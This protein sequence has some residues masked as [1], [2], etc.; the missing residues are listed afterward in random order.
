MFLQY[1]AKMNIYDISKENIAIVVNTL[2]DGSI[3]NHC[4]NNWDVKRYRVDNVFQNFILHF[5]FINCYAG[6]KKMFANKNS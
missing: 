3:I 4:F 2:L 5:C 6:N 1:F